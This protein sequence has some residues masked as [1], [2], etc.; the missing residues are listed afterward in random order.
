VLANWLANQLA[1][2]PRAA[3]FLARAPP[4]E[5]EGNE[6]HGEEQCRAGLWHDEAKLDMIHLDSRDGAQ[7]GVRQL[8]GDDAIR[9]LYAEE[10]ERAGINTG[11]S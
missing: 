2:W 11:L 4:R 1:N 8:D 7:P 10:A 9:I 6:T 5:S 3:A